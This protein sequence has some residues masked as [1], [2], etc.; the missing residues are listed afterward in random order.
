MASDQNWSL[1]QCEEAVGF[2]KEGWIHPS[3]TAEPEGP[4][5]GENRRFWIARFQRRRVK[6]GDKNSISKKGEGGLA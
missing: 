1:A 3:G 5:A 6:K 4:G 2:P